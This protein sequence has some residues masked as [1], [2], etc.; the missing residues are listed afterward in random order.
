MLLGIDVGN[1]KTALGLFSG[2][3][4]LRTWQ[5]STYPLGTSDELICKIQSLLESTPWHWGDL[6]SVLISSVVPQFTSVLRKTF[7]GMNCRVIDSTWKYS[8]A[9]KANPPHQVGTDRLVNAEAAVREYGFPLII[10]DSGTATTLCAV[11]PQR[12]YLGGSIMPGI[13]GSM[14][15]L[16][17]RAAQLFA[18]ELK[19]P[20]KSIGTNT[21]EALQSGILLGYASMID[22]MIARF[23]KELGSDEIKVIATGGVAA[24]LKGITKDIDV[25]D[26]LLTLK[27]IRYLNESNSG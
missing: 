21:E 7:A 26:S 24:L 9:I 6:T 8:F 22:G 2:A 11:S 3:E 1:T 4:V 19:P 10:V 17:Q 14:Q 16:A 18:V 20:T 5:I 15:M 12:E 25:F 23:K 27:G 13:E